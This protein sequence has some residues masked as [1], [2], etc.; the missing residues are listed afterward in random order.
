MNFE[1]LNTPEKVMEFINCINYGW[2][3]IDGNIRKNTIKGF[4]KLY[5][6]QSIEELID[7]RCGICIDD[8]E[9]ER[10]LLSSHYQ[11]KSF[12]I[13]TSHIFHAFLLLEKDGVITY[14]EYSSY[15]NRGIYHFLTEQEALEFVLSNF[16]KQHKIRNRKKLSLVE[17]PAIPPHTTFKELKEILTNRPNL[18][19][20]K[21][22]MKTY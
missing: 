21:K 14:F 15:P 2:M 22:D 12:A 13:I 3:G 11:T 20:K 17:Y 10:F 9:L 8:V 4:Q 19:E 5:Q 7:T 18:L 1:S 16:I 6:T